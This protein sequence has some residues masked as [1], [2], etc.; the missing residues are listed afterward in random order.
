VSVVG[1]LRRIKDPFRA[2]EAVRELP[3]ASRLRVRHVGKGLEPG[4]EREARRRA[5]SNR[6]YAWLGDRAVWET[7]REIARSR[8]LVLTSRFEGGANVIS[9]AVVSAVPVVSSRMACSEG[10][11]GRDYPGLFPIGDTG[12]LRELLV[13]AEME[14]AFLRE[15]RAR[16]RRLRPLFAPSRELRAWG[17]LIAELG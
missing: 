17:S 9:E 8:L 15:L 13:R 16:C 11:L 10:L 12:A 5:A 4:M 7:R 6:R 3:A 1:H 14:P 2:E